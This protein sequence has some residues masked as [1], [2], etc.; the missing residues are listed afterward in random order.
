MLV[1]EYL[2]HRGGMEGGGKGGLKE[3]WG[4][5]FTLKENTL[6]CILE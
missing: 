3:R 2:A 5:L 4:G 6:Y 1:R